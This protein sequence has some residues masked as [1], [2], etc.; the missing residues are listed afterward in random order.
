[1][2]KLVLFVF[3]SLLLVNCSSLHQSVPKRETA[4][5]EEDKLGPST[6]IPP[7]R[8]TSFGKNDM[9]IINN[10]T[11]ALYQRVD[12]IRRAK[13]SLELEYF[14]FNPDSAGRIIVTELIKAVKR[15]VAVRV[16]VDKS[17]AVFVL[18][19]SYA[20]IFRDNSIQLRYYNPASIFRISSV[21]FRNHRKLII[22]D[23][24]E[25]IT[26]G[27]NI[28]DEYFNLS[29][30][31]NFLDRDV[32]VK[33]DIVPAMHETFERYWVS[34]II[35]VPRFL[36]IKKANDSEKK[37]YQEAVDKMAF[38][39][40][41]EHKLDFIMSYG[42][43]ALNQNNVHACP[44][45]TLGTDREGASFLERIHSKDYKAN[46]RLLR[47]EIAKWI[48][49]NVQHEIV[50][51]TPY[52]LIDPNSEDV[53][54]KLLSQNK[55]VTILTNSLASTDAAYVSTVF[56]S[57]VTKYTKN[58]NFSAYTYKGKFSD[59]SELYSDEV[60]RS[61]WGTHSKTIVF[62]DDSFMIGTFN[63]DNRSS[64]YN[65]EMAI[66]CSG[67]PELTQD[68]R[69]NISARMNMSYH[70]NSEG[71][72]DDGT[73]LLEGNSDQ[74]KRLYYFLKVPSSIL[75]FLL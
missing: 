74:K 52:F 70:L 66:F 31:F 49:N 60:R 71:V 37:K 19:E 61:D 13:R 75:Q 17:A 24:E 9:R 34:D 64:F 29:T 18:D 4:S 45:A 5:V 68:I 50:V 15:G 40:E 69:S 10:G 62:N 35:E 38:T 27:R 51:D 30:T 72:P 20:K 7:Y 2:K 73:P 42:E 63:I 36:N 67:S 32:W 47:K 28:A 44:E 14:I 65:T 11:A 41:D 25:A 6:D 39:K 58:P 54:T 55:K 56:N 46:Y 59:E 53:L 3:L 22:R 8:T 43:Q 57:S 33:G 12:M 1:M 21:Q 48:E 26:G 16:L 23:N